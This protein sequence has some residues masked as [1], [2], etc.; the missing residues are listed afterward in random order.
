MNEAPEPEP[1][2]VKEAVVPAAESVAST[3]Q[4]PPPVEQEINVEQATA[5]ETLPEPAEA[6]IELQTTKEAPS[7]TP[8]STASE[9]E[10]S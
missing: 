10:V 9:T 8:E 1:Q 4:T 5:V 7:K 6:K 3:S 2:A